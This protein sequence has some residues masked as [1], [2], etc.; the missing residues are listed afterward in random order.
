MDPLQQPQKFKK[1][2]A[3][4]IV[5]VLFLFLLYA[6][7]PYRNAIFGAVILYVIFHQLYRRMLGIGMAAELAAIA[8]I[9]L[10][11]LIVILPVWVIVSLSLDQIRKLPTL[12]TENEQLMSFISTFT[13]RIEPLNWEADIPSL[14]RELIAEGSRMLQGLF[15]SF[16]GNISDFVIG[17]TIMYFLLFYM[18]VHDKRLVEYVRSVIP[19]NDHHTKRIMQELFNVTYSTVVGQGII[20]LFQGTGLG[21]GLWVLGI[22]GAFFWAV[23]GVFLAFLPIIGIPLIWI[24]LGVVQLFGGNY[25][26]G[27]AILI[28]GF[29]LSN[30]DNYLR[31]IINSHM[32]SLHPLISLVGVFFGLSY[33]GIVGIIVGPLL[34]SSFFLLVQMYREEFLEKKKSR[35][36]GSI[37]P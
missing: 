25:L 27:I 22:P 1:A 23:F 11:M 4:A 19:F 20:S 13:F 12:I 37:E 9:I 3:L 33:F 21:I 14:F 29:I 10:S 5:V 30:V 6:L 26:V 7:L 18:F 24:P 2:I 17:I 31:L 8:N 32:A 35:T 28:W 36:K 34:L 15:F 16:V